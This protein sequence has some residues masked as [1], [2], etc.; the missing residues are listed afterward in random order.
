M[1]AKVKLA[2]ILSGIFICMIGLFFGTS[3][4]KRIPDNPPGTVGNTTGNLYNSGL[5]CET[6][7]RIYFANAYDNGSLYVMNTD[8]SNIKKL[9]EGNTN[10]INAGGDYLYYLQMSTQSG[11]AGLGYLRGITGMYR[12]RKNGK[13]AVGLSQ[14]ALGCIKLVDNSVYYQNYVKG[15]GVTLHRMDTD[16]KNDIILIDKNITPA[17]T[18][19]GQIYYGGLE[20]DHNL[21]SVDMNTGM[22]TVVLQGNLCYPT[23]ENGYVYY[24]DIENNYRLCRVSLT[25]PD[26]GATVLTQDRV[27]LYN[28]YGSIIF[29]QRNSQTDPALV[30]MNIDGTN[31]EV[32][33]EGNYTNVNCTGNYTYFTLFGSD[34]PVYKTSTYGSINV[35]TFDAARDAALENME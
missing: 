28:V 12:I 14:D 22:N 30:R 23:V 24:M 8:E 25:N 13:K 5:F 20:Q 29:Y 21:Y 33:A 7:D 18:Y 35:T 31:P 32:V 34:V 6:E 26:E 10:F 3:L 9:H 11:G 2:L 4:S 17:A 15:T 16:K 27:D 1:N 19:Q